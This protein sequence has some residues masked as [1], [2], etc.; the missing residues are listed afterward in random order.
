MRTG[1]VKKRILRFIV[2]AVIAAVG[3]LLTGCGAKLT[4]Y[5]Y[6][7]NG[8]RYNMYELE[9]DSS[10]VALME[11]TAA[12]D[13]DGNKYTVEGYFFTFFKSFGY[14]LK[15]A[16]VADGKYVATYSKRITGESEL[17]AIGSKVEFSYTHTDDPFIRTYVA[18]APNPFN[19][20][21]QKYDNL[22][23]FRSTTM[24]ER[25]KNGVV[26][27]NEYGEVI[28]SFPSL[29]EAFPYLDG[30]DPDGLMLD[31][32][33]GGARR[34]ESSGETLSSSGSGATYKF[35]RY[36]DASDTEISFRY[37]RPV[38]YGWY[39][40]AIAAGG[41]TLAVF[42]LVTREKKKKPSLLERFPYDPEAYA[43]ERQYLPPSGNDPD[44][45]DGVNNE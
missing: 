15:S 2:L 19:G 38:V 43:Y 6:T 24:L 20:V 13:D 41:I 23:P 5:D 45:G 3:M 31:Y 37:E 44:N 16:S 26:A 35:S 29:T 32:V 36:F 21:R 1:I 42:V 14:E 11:S 33:R 30:A 27:R 9:I 17:D 18:T 40:V 7:E 25:I 39:M 4:V 28:K 22:E 34:M 12:V 8:A 10:V